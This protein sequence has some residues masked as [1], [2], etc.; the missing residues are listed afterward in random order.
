MFS[1]V[2]VVMTQSSSALLHLG[3]L[4]LPLL[5]VFGD[6][7]FTFLSLSFLHHLLPLLKQRK[8]EASATVAS[9]RLRV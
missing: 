9:S 1:G 5:Q 4:L 3:H 2:D 6:F 7:D 8:Q